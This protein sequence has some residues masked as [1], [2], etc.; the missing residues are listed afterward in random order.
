[1]T[2]EE[3]QT[4]PPEQASPSG[5]SSALR[6]THALLVEV[7]GHQA[8]GP[9]RAQVRLRRLEVLKGT[10]EGRETSLVVPTWPEVPAPL[11][12]PVSPWQRVTLQAGGRLLALAETRESALER[13]LSHPALRSL[14]PGEAADEV[15]A[16]LA[17][18]SQGA[19]AQAALRVV[20]S[21]R[22]GAGP[23]LGEWLLHHLVVPL[24]SP[25]PLLEDVRALLGAPDAAPAVREALARGLY[26]AALLSWE[27]DPAHAHALA[28]AL[29][30]GTLRP[31]V[32]APLR[33]R[34]AAGE[35]R[36]LLIDTHPPPS[37]V[38][39]LPDAAARERARSALAALG[40]GA[41]GPL[42]A[43]LA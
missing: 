23:L 6:A 18:E 11:Q 42:S 34:L 14:W 17:A 9:D 15:R 19:G 24:H 29:L 16:L 7:T 1:M 4:T 32:P 12:R 8:A 36:A 20:A 25:G 39:L 10:S 35:L 40:P 21:H 33:H 3:S 30:E 38:A 41:A 22:A 26:E 43:W 37:A 27:R 31:E 13:V 28:R 5:R 2:M